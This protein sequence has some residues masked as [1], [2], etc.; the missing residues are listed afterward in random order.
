[1]GSRTLGLTALPA[2]LV[3]VSAGCHSPQV[4]VTGSAATEQL[5]LTQAWD[6]ALE[7]VNFSPLIGRKVYLDA[8]NIN[9]SKNGWMTYRIRE[10]MSR[11]GVLLQAK[12]EDAEL[13][14]EAGAGVYGSDAETNY[15]G[16]PSST[17]VGATTAMPSVSSGTGTIGQC[18]DQYGAATLAMFAYERDSRKFVWE[19]G[20][21]GAGSCS[22]VMYLPLLPAFRRG[23]IATPAQIMGKCG[24]PLSRLPMPRHFL[25]RKAGHCQ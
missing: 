7:S 23:T 9:S 22:H 18:V 6:R 20:T 25:S 16:I 10:A 3:F 12:P 19:S 1:M 5:L 11:Q 24:S 4:T 2:L 8:S 17:F 15:I 13:I 14:V 21:I